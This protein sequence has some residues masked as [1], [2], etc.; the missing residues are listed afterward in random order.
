PDKTPA[1]WEIVMTNRVPEDAELTDVLEA[2]GDPDA[3]TIL[4]ITHKALERGNSDFFHHLRDRRHARAIP[5]RMSECGYVSVHNRARKDGRWPI[6]T[7]KKH[8][9]YVKAKLSLRQRHEAVEALTNMA[10]ADITRAEEER[11]ELLARDDTAR[12]A[13]FSSIWV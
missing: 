4:Q 9:I 5:H 2:L 13:Q 1:F 11:R 7:S 10:M 12:A 6:G 3:V 8:I